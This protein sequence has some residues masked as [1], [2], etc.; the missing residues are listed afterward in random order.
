MN[1]RDEAEL[2]WWREVFSCRI[3]PGSRDWVRVG[4]PLLGHRLKITALDPED[5]S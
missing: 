4:R 5:Q 3:E 1:T 2:A